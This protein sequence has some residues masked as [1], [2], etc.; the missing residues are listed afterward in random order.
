MKE[1]FENRI[2]L[3]V[4]E[5]PKYWYNLQA[6]LPTA[7]APALNPKTLEPLTPQ[8]L[9]PIFPKALIMQEV[10]KE[11][12]IEIPSEVRE[13]YKNWRSTPLYRAK[14]LEKALD[15][16]ARI[17][18]KYEGGNP[19]GSHK[20]NTAIAQAYYNREEGIKRIATETGAGQ[21]GSAMAMA[22]QMFGMECMVYMVKVSYEGKPYRRAF[23]ELFDGKIV[24]SPSHCTEYGRTILAEDPDCTGSLGIAISEAVEDTLSRE[25]THYCLGSV[26]NHVS[27]HQTI[28]GQETKLQ[29]AKVDDYPDIVIACHG[30]GTNFAGIAFPFLRDKLAGEN[31]RII[32]AEPMA[33]PTLTKG[34]FA[35]DFGDTAKISPVCK[36]YTLGHDFMPSG[37]HAGGLRYHG[38]SPLVSHVMNEGYIEAQAFGQK[39]C[40]QAAELFSKIEKIIPAPESA[41]A[42]RCAID[43]AL[44]A[45]EEGTSPTIVFNLSGHGYFDM[46]AYQDYKSGLLTDSPFDEAAFKKSLES[47]PQVKE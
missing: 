15:T 31:I 44:K 2:F 41:H 26:L 43:E 35:Y 20:L 28:I 9:E 7:P 39:E 34:V 47:L 4:D 8:D 1:Y 23:V 46:Q 18:Y 17:Y 10:S 45:K 38:S 42:I 5:L 11:R 29:L 32:A 25:D 13:Y 40:F 33:C 6:D 19:T 14:S 12:Y 16:S 21:W 27:L 37:I 22:C 36:M 30:G 24:A 3:T